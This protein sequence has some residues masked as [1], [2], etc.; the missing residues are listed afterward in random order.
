MGHERLTADTENSKGEQSGASLT[1][2]VVFS[3]D[4]DNGSGASCEGPRG[5][6]WRTRPHRR[7]SGGAVPSSWAPEGGR[8]RR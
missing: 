3:H 6:A 4:G 1:A 2:P 7:G 5:Q 8:P